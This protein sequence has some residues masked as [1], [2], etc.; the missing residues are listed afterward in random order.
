MNLRELDIRLTALFEELEAID[1][2][3]TIPDDRDGDKPISFQMYERLLR[4]G[5]EGRRPTLHE[6]ID[7][8]VAEL[9]LVHRLVRRQL[10][11]DGESPA[12]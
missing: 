1:L 7:S 4:E 12:A 6:W 9:R 11:K 2:D 3:P 10:L 5:Y 8:E